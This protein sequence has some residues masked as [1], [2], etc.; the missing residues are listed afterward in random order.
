MDVCLL[1]Q[2]EEQLA[3]CKKELT[4]MRNSFLS[5]D[6]EDNNGL[7]VLQGDLEGEIFDF[8]LQIKKVLHT[9]TRTANSLTA[10]SHS[11]GVKLPKLDMPT[12]DGNILQW[13]TYW[14]QFC[15]SV[16]DRSNLA[17]SEKFVYLQ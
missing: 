6:L 13:R 11:Q 3:H 4:D 2:Y 16:H 17:D 14:E 5:I 8:S 12:F 7:S 15:V 9:S 10:H 1:R